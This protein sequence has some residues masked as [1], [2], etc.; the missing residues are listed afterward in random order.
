MIDIRF[1]IFGYYEYTVDNELLAK[2]FEAFLRDGIRI[3]KSEKGF[4]VC[5]LDKKRAEALMATRVKFLRSEMLGLGGVFR[6]NTKRI[7]LFI[8]LLITIAVANFASDVVWDVRIE[9]AGVYSDEEIIGE[10]S[11]CGL[12]VGD[13]WSK[14]DLSEIENE[15]LR[16]SEKISWLNVNRRGTVAYVKIIEKKINSEKEKQG[17][18]NIVARCD[19]V[20]EEISVI[21]G[22]AKVSVGDSVRAG[23]VLIMGAYTGGAGG[24]FCYAEGIVKGRVSDTL[25]VNVSK[26]TEEKIVTEEKISKIDLKIFNF[27]I[28]IFKSYRNSGKDCD[29]IVERDVISFLNK[30]LPVWKVAYIVRNYST[31][32]RTLTDGETVKLASEDM[33]KLI[34]ERTADA[35]LLKLS[36]EGSFQGDFYNMR[37]DIVCVEDIAKDAPFEY[38]ANGENDGKNCDD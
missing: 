13:R 33:E 26:N 28:N 35:T 19:A 3:V 36:T 20:I 31:V 8:A 11:A 37:T 22:V 17:F 21:R 30:E 6:K 23:D 32:S 14:T 29:I 24:G 18:S 2:L 4:Y 1:F 16:T 5:S 12:S 38:S 9:G 7:G 10:L 15:L 34:S 27:S 25:T